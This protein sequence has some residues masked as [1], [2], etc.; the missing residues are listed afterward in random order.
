MT[1]FFDLSESKKKGLNVSELCEYAE[2]LEINIHKISEK[3]GKNIKKTKHE[4][5]EELDATYMKNKIDKIIE[6]KDSKKKSSKSNDNKKPKIVLSI[7]DH[8]FAEN[9]KLLSDLQKIN[10]VQDK[11]NL[12]CEFGNIIFD[13]NFYFFNE[14]KTFI[15]LEKIKEDYLKIPRSIT[16]Y[17]NNS[18]EFFKKL[19]D[20]KFKIGCLEL[21]KNDTYIFN[22]LEADKFNCSGINFNYTYCFEKEIYK[23]EIELNYLG[24]KKVIDER[25]NTFKFFP[26]KDISIIQLFDFHNK[27]S[28]NQ[29]LFKFKMYGPL[30]MDL[31]PKWTDIY[32]I[33]NLIKGCHKKESDQ[34]YYECEIYATMYSRYLNTLNIKKQYE[35]ELNSSHLDELI[36]ITEKDNEYLLFI[37]T[38]EMKEFVEEIGYLN[39][40]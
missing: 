30:K 8:E 25:F 37:D 11:Y 35:K 14:D 28:S 21:N 38:N 17:L 33:K 7:S 5:I 9:T 39:L 2:R 18:V 3:T 16:K 15:L 20:K 26:K 19:K 36:I 34:S 4:I 10:Y 23:L 29:F 6:N 1:S 32:F 13:G 31:D 40:I 27:L 12:K 22:Y 24:Q